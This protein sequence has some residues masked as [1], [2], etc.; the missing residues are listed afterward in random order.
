MAIISYLI[1][2]HSS[3]HR[4]FTTSA[5]RIFESM[6]SPLS[7]LF[8]SPSVVMFAFALNNKRTTC[9]V[10]CKK[11]RSCRHDATRRTK[12][13]FRR[14]N[15]R[16][17]R[18]ISRDNL[19]RRGGHV[20]RHGPINKAAYLL[21]DKSP[22]NDLSRRGARGCTKI[23]RTTFRIDNVSVKSFRHSCRE[24]LADKSEL[25]MEINWSIQRYTSD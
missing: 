2:I 20:D 11:R 18:S 15:G 16:P 25:T 23:F 5:T 4:L 9:A 3:Y 21:Q 12:I 6:Y 19:H 22:G 14:R 13:R 1:N 7:E 8:T 24:D 17:L 10:V